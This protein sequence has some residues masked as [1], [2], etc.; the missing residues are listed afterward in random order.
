LQKNEALKQLQEKGN[1][2]D[3]AGATKGGNYRV[4]K[5]PKS[6]KDLAFSGDL[7]NT[8]GAFTFCKKLL[9]QARGK[10]LV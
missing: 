10:A 3:E 1:E 7:A 9:L 6:P 8:N 5:D 4:F 2:V